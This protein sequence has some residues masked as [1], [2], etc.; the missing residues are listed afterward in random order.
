[1]LPNQEREIFARRCNEAYVHVSFA[2]V[3]QPAK[4]ILLKYF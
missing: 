4:A 3:A 2:D 1:M